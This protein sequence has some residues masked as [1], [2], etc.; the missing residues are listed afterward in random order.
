MTRLEML[1][2]VRASGSGETMDRAA[3]FTSA[4]CAVHCVLGPI[5][6]PLLPVATGQFVGPGLEWTFTA[7]SVL[8]GASSLGH[9]YRA[10]HRNPVPLL[11]FG[12]GVTFLILAKFLSSDSVALELSAV[13]TGATCI[14][15]THVQNLRMHRAL[16]A[17]QECPC[18]CHDE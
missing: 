5:I 2:I 9:S 6:L 4:A 7:A 10:L 3:T 18:P 14:I 8:L 11:W 16:R 13:A 12:V 17:N 1:P 15:A